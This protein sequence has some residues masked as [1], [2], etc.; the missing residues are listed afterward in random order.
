MLMYGESVLSLLSIDIPQETSQY[1]LT[2]YFS[3]TT[4]VLL[5]YLHFR[6]EPHH[7]DDHVLRQNKDLAMLWKFFRF[8]YSA[9][10]ISLGS[11]YTLFVTSFSY[12]ATS[13]GGYGSDAVNDDGHHRA[14]RHLA[15]GGDTAY[16]PD[17]MIQRASYMFSA[18]LALVY[19]SMDASSFM[20][21][22]FEHSRRRCYCKK[23]RI[24]NIKGV[25]LIVF[26]A[27]LISFCATLGVWCSDDVEVL[28]GLGLAVTVIQLGTRRLGE[29]YLAKRME[30]LDGT[31]ES[32]VSKDEDREGNARTAA[33]VDEQ[34]R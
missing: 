32:S 4:V 5:H 27:A 15:G 26:R 14:Q 34:Y 30:S 12:P 13:D 2:F 6:S 29:T 28:S 7:A 11:A 8:S 1:Y 22:G 19:L 24:A 25:T 21:L 17:E 20:H 9:S 23:S 33:G 10:L 16:P 18:S 3:L 31:E